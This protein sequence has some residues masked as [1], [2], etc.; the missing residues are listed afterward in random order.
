MQSDLYGYAAFYFSF[1]IL[2][3]RAYSLYDQTM[4]DGHVIHHLRESSTRKIAKW[5]SREQIRAVGGHGTKQDPV[6]LNA[7]GVHSRCTLNYHLYADN[8]QVGKDK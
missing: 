5:H 1:S 3:T 7:V 6:D 2:A 4:K 8:L